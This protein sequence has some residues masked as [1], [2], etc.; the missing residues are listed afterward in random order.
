MAEVENEIT[1]E[2]RNKDKISLNESGIIQNKDRISLNESGIGQDTSIIHTPGKAYLTN[3]ESGIGRDLC[4]NNSLCDGFGGST[5][6]SNDGDK[7]IL[8]DSACADMTEHSKNGVIKETDDTNKCTIVCEDSNNVK[9]MC[10]MKQNDETK[11]M[12]DKCDGTNNFTDK[13]IGIKKDDSGLDLHRSPGRD[14]VSD[15]DVSES[16]SESG[17]M[18]T[19]T[20]S[21]LALSSKLSE[22]EDSSRESY[23][24][25]VG[26]GMDMDES[27]PSCDVT[28]PSGDD[29]E[30]VKE[31]GNE[32]ESESEDEDDEVIV[33]TR[34]IKRKRRMNRV[35]S[36]SENEST[37]NES[38][39]N[40]D[41]DSSV[42]R[43]ED[44]LDSDDDSDVE[45]KK[46]SESE[47]EEE[48]TFENENLKQTFKAIK[49]LRNREYGYS[50]KIPPSHFREKVQGSVN[51]VKRF[52]LQCKLEYHDGCVNALHF[53][54]IGTLLASG[55]DDLNIVLWNWIRKRPA[56]YYDSGHR[57][58][59]FQAKF[60][61][62][63]G[64]CHV[65]SCARDGQ[66]RLAEL[67]LT[68]VCKNTKKLAQHKG[69]A[70]KL[71]LEHDSP[72]V[73]LSCGEDA[74]VYGVDLREEKPTKLALTK[75]GDKRIPLYS[76]HSNPGNSFEF[77]V[78]GRDHF[79][80]V[81]DKRKIDKDD[82]SSGLLKKFCPHHL[83][84][85]DVKANV[86]CAV[87]NYNGTEIIGSYNDEDIYM[88]NNYHTEGAEYV[89]R[90]TGHRNNHT[91]KGV[92]FY[93]PKSEFIV[94]GS[95]CGH[96]FLWDKETEQIVQ[97]LTGDDNGAINVLEPHPTLPVLATS[98]LDHE[99]KIWSPMAEQP[100]DLKGIKKATK[101]N[102]KERE[103][104]R[105]HDVDMIDG[106][107]LW[108]IMH[109]MPRARRRREREAE[110]DRDSTSTENSE[111]DSS[112]SDDIPRIPCAPS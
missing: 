37:E 109:H 104:E 73:F 95:D 24:A 102:M 12:T 72:H 91:V 18:S 63:S 106:Q 4:C 3:D 57:S 25:I 110:G 99:V 38:S 35:D 68:G 103:D 50:K 30:D 9:T 82:L 98:G 10:D 84:D 49:D 96:V 112:D 67:S 105:I 40:V 26:Q 15:L 56:L 31:T 71:A 58:N 59:V 61:P 28:M 78:S 41:L 108:Y 94:S 42:H 16:H 47:S 69:A 87:Y 29:D 92:N 11:K 54:R 48:E 21:G 5:N 70:H 76:I 55:S 14:G 88:F 80:R 64:D 100:T 36:S 20:D 23:N 90:Y 60:M 83:V 89:K 52:E 2:P 44:V 66:I 39:D 13:S 22:N 1:T 6:C 74:L 79:I 97:Y 75:E 46:S 27:E 107:M 19:K 45:Q 7:S 33:R 62:F 17:A 32:S 111:N 85:S 8:G 101:R 53:N 86:T 81:Y 43:S 93:G 65:V 77:C 34:K 51:L